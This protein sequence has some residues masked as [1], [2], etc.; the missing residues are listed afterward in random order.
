[1]AL[2]VDAKTTCGYTPLHM[3]AMYGHKKLLRI[4][5][6]KF[7]ADVRLR[8]TSGRRAWQYLEGEDTPPDLLQMLGAPKQKKKKKRMMTAKRP[9]SRDGSPHRHHD[10]GG[11]SEQPTTST[12]TVK[13]H[14]SLA[15]LFKHKHL[16]RL[17]GHT[18]MSV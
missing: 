1:M 13:R 5:V 18:E 8:D 14:S 4:L 15:A 3:A 10:D 2:D 7:K 11:S 16:A 17:T 6:L 12:T 9:C